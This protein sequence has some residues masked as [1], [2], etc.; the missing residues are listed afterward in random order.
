MANILLA[1]DI[2]MILH[3]LSVIFTNYGHNIVGTAKNC[4]ECIELYKETN[5]DIV[6]LDILGMD[7]YSSELGKRIDSFDTIKILRD[8][9]PQA[10]II[11]LTA[12]PKEEYI[13]KALLAGAKNFLV[14]GVSN[15]KVIRTLEKALEK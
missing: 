7:T 4:V 12:T 9:D 5:P 8:I 14:K 2:K 6:F 13:K 3:N 11:I 15:E 10:K 1:D